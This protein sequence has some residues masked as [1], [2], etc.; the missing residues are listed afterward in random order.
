MKT[1]IALLS[2]LAALTAVLGGSAAAV[3]FF[4]P[5]PSIGETTSAEVRQPPSLPPRIAASLARQAIPNPPQEKE[6]IKPVVAIPIYRHPVQETIRIQPIARLKPKRTRALKNEQ[7][8][9]YSDT[10][11]SLGY[12]EPRHLRQV[13]S[14]S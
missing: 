7:A 5:E 8:L 12:A 9:G 2:Y 13:N 10:S 11:S 4:L 14:R 1:L 6:E 3:V